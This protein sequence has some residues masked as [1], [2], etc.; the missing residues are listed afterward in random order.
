[1]YMNILIISKNAHE[2]SMKIDYRIVL[3]FILEKSKH[4][5][6]QV[7]FILKIVMSSKS[8]ITEVPILILSY[9]FISLLSLPY[10]NAFI[11]AN[12]GQFGQLGDQLSG[13]ADGLYKNIDSWA[14]HVISHAKDEDC[15]HICPYGKL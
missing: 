6:K 12:T 4:H 10:S 1:M 3:T 2:K 15:Q 5:F 7:V 8:S 14:D 13:Y 9:G 11:D